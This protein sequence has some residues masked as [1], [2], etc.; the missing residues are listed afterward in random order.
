MKMINKTM[1]LVIE[2]INTMYKSLAKLTKKKK[3]GLI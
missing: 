1:S 2:K 3:R